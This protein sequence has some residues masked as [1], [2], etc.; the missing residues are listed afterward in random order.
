MFR[1]EV[2]CCC[3][4]TKKLG[5]LPVMDSVVLGQNIDFVLIRDPAKPFKW[6]AGAT[7]SKK[8]ETIRFEVAKWA[9]FVPLTPENR[10]KALS[11]S[12]E[13][14]MA[15]V[16]RGMALKHENVTIE[17]LRRIPGFLEAS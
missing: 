17:T 7:I 9:D 13:E 8:R 16:D 1:M 14:G 10:K 2:R 3:Q 5:T 15:L 6:H 4:P 12:E 11:I